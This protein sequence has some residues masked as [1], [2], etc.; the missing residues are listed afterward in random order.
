[1]KPK[2]GICC[3]YYAIL[4]IKNAKRKVLS[5]INSQRPLTSAPQD[6]E[7]SAQSY[8]GPLW[9]PQMTSFH[10]G[11]YPSYQTFAWFGMFVQLASCPL[12]PEV[13]IGIS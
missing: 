7:Q 2:N 8:V 12:Q 1:M 13:K 10:F 9:A 11:R 5:K 4:I 3:S 6:Q